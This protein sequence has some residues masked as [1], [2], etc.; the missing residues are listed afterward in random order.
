VKALDFNFEP[1]LAATGWYV[2]LSG[3]LD[4]MVL[5]HQI[6]RLRSLDPTSY[7]KLE[8]IHVNHGL[9]ED[10]DLWERHCL[11]FCHAHD[12][13]FYSERANIENK[14]AG[15]ESAAR[16]ARYRIFETYLPS[17]SVLFIGHHLEDQIETFFLRLMRGAGL[18][19]LKSIPEIRMLGKT[20]LVRPLLKSPRVELEAYA[21]KHNIIPV[22]DPSNEDISY[23]RNF[24]RHQVLPVLETRWPGYR[25]TIARAISHIDEAHQTRERLL[26]ENANIVSQCGDPG[27]SIESMKEV[28]VKNSNH[29]V[30]RFLA[31]HGLTMPNESSLNEFVRQLLYGGKESS[32]LLRIR[33]RQVRRFREGIFLLPSLSNYCSN[34]ML[35]L[36]PNEVV[37][38]EGVGSICLQ[39]N[40]KQKLIS[41]QGIEV[42][43][44]WRSSDVISKSSKL[45]S[46]IKKIFNARAIPPWWRDRVPMAFIENELIVIGSLKNMNL[47]SINESVWSLEWCVPDGIWGESKSV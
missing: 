14:G 13:S 22:D 2:A 24:L 18:K 20:T 16:E 33:D 42:I 44:C 7:P 47:K 40:S 37:K 11:S 3:G 26:P 32:A 46:K 5:L 15:L 35:T 31:E 25:A 8:A 34:T 1:F 39:M 41:T 45:R 17:S 21:L 43:L 36:F 29:M 28:G 23:D 30:R 4:S 10:A 19:G 27:L 6:N 12:I 9:H 38:I